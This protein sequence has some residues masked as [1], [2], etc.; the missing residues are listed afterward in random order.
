M[1]FVSMLT[2]TK[3]GVSM[4]Q[5]H[6]GAEITVLNPITK[7]EYFENNRFVNHAAIEILNADSGRLITISGTAISSK[8]AAATLNFRLLEYI[9]RASTE[10]PESLNYRKGPEA[11]WYVIRTEDILRF[12]NKHYYFPE[13]DNCQR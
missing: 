4:V 8:E 3:I 2:P 6:L 5:H 7:T 11:T 9:G 12:L 10:D 13:T 1:H